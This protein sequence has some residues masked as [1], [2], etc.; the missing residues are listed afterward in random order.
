MLN[1]VTIWVGCGVSCIAPT[2]LPLGRDLTEFLLDN[3]IL[4]KDNILKIWNEIND[5]EKGKLLTTEFPRLELIISSIIYVERYYLSNRVGKG[6]SNGMQLF[7]LS[8]Y[9]RNHELIAYLVNAGANVM[10]ANFDYGI[11]KAYEAIY[12]K[13]CGN[14]IIHFHGTFS[15]KKDI[16]TTIENITHYINGTVEKKLKY[17]FKPKHVN[18]FV[19]YSFSD[20]YDINMMIRQL[21]QEKGERT[22]Q[23]FVCNHNGLDENLKRRA[24]DLFGESN[25]KVVNQNCTKFLED[26]CDRKAVIKQSTVVQEENK[27]DWEK[28]FESRTDISEELRV[29]ST[30]HLLNRMNIAPEKVDKN[31]MERYLNIPIDSEKKEIIEYYLALN[32]TW[33]YEK[34][35]LT[36]LPN[37]F[38]KNKVLERRMDYNFQKGFLE[39][40]ILDDKIEEICNEFK[41]KKYVYQEGFF[42]LTRQININKWK[43]INNE[44]IIN[45]NAVKKIL[46]AISNFPVGKFPELVYYASMLRYQ[47]LTCVSDTRSEQKLYKSANEI[48]YDIACVSGI[49]ASGLDLFITKKYKHDLT[50]DDILK[51]DDWHKLKDF[52]N[53]LGTYRYRCLIEIIENG[54]RTPHRY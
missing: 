28:I 20:M 37:D 8:P 50:W 45:W 29:L 44:E 40:Q 16:G 32:S 7:E 39:N 21:Y 10:T 14:K 36:R 27:Y 42:E 53:S 23:N 12:S 17:C 2:C 48:Y 13:K 41:S 38:Y 47:M 24:I 43:I 1:N 35:K 4:C 30:I 46:E 26:L 31:L 18:I 54:G 25:I 5:Y 9:N 15:D 3:V 51:L 19:G 52:C 22:N 11:E 49:I 34:Y 33:W 6:F